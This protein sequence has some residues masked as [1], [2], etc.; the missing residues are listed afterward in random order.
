MPQAS[1][2][3]APELKVSDHSQYDIVIVG[4][5]MVGLSLALLLCHRVPTYRICVVDYFAL[6][7]PQHLYQPSFDARSTAISADSVAIFQSLG[8]WSA[9]AKR[10]TSIDAVHVTDRG[11][12][13]ATHY[14]RE[15]NRG[16]ALGYVADNEWLGCCLAETI[17]GLPQLT[18]LAPAQVERLQFFADRVDCSII[19][20]QKRAQTLRSAL[21]IAADGA[22]SSLRECLG[23]AVEQHDYRQVALIANITFEKP[24]QGVAFERFTAAGP[25]A[26]L[27]RGED[28]AARSAGLVWTIPEA[29][30]DTVLAWSDEEFLAALQQAFG[31]RLGKMLRLGKRAHYPLKRILAQ[32]QV[33]SR[34]ALMGNAAHYLHP[35]AGQGFNLALRDGETLAATLATGYAQGKDP[36]DLALLQQ[37]LNKQHTDQWLTAMISHSFTGVFTRREK[38]VQAFRNMGLLGINLVPALK[39]AFFQKM[40]GRG[41]YFGPP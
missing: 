39:H 38:G 22:H 8:I 40:M 15:H 18:V 13:G 17:A 12:V 4:G 32:E 25:L 30:L 41:A 3:K 29:D 19:D 9:I 26:I 16:E 1:N 23:I 14:H 33:R 37:Y 10:A 34:F 11:H 6:S 21:V 7:D 5:G 35:V 24:H 20:E 36:G 27:P 31:Y 28:A 2:V